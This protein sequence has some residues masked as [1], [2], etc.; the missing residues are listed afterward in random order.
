MG[1][2]NALNLKVEKLGLRVWEGAEF[3]G[4]HWRVYGRV[5]KGGYME[6]IRILLGYAAI[7]VLSWDSCIS[8]IGFECEPTSFQ[9]LPCMGHPYSSKIFGRRA[10]RDA[11]KKP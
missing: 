9:Q 1:S 8:H 3:Q 6:C 10:V 5:Y 11:K 7:R 2:G 4:K